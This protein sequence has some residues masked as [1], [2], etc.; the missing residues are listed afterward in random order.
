[1]ARGSHQTSILFLIPPN[2]YFKLS[3]FPQFS[4][5]ANPPHCPIFKLHSPRGLPQFPVSPYSSLTECL[6]FLSR[7]L[8]SKADLST[9]SLNHF[10]TPHPHHLF[11]LCVGSLSSK[12]NQLTL[13]HLKEHTQTVLDLTY[14]PF[15][16]HLCF[17]TAELSERAHVQPFPPSTPSS[18][19]SLLFSLPPRSSHFCPR[20]GSNQGHW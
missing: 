1:M 16:H 11:S 5:Y 19:Q 18:H 6:P 8:R 15:S 7:L 3:P 9:P 17:F 14:V 10:L 20:H 4:S 12:N 13:S 2:D